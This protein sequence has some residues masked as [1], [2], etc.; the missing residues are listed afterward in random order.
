[1]KWR[2]R[3]GS[4][5]VLVGGKQDRILGL[6]PSCAIEV[7]DWLERLK[8]H[9]EQ[10]PPKPSVSSSRFFRV[11]GPYGPDCLGLDKRVWDVW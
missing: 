3:D 7:G 2:L 10:T 5:Q 11:A 4:C 1:M 8:L 6:S 9:L